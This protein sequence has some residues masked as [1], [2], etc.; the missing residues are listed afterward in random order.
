[1]REL[2]GEGVGGEHV[3]E[4][5]SFAGMCAQARLLKE[6]APAWVRAFQEAGIE[7]MLMVP[8]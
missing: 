5:Y 6:S 3:P 4:A 2:A 7:A 8:V 1:M